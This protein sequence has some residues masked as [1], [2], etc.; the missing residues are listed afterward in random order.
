M[1]RLVTLSLKGGVGKTTLALNLGMAL[2]ILGHRVLLVD[3][4]PQQ[5]LTQN[6][7]VEPYA[8][9]GV[10]FLLTKDMK[11][12]DL[13]IEK[14]YL[15]LLPAGKRLKDTEVAL[16]Q[17]VEKIP[18]VINLL[19][20]GLEEYHSQYDYIIVDSPPNTGLLAVN[21]LIFAREIV[22]PVQCHPMGLR[23]AK[24]TLFFIHKIR[25]YYNSGLKISAVIP[26]MF[27]ARNTLSKNVLN[28][29]ERLFNN[30]TI[31]SRVRVNVDIARASGMQKS[32]FEYRA[33]SRGAQDFLSL[34][35]EIQEISD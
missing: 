35:R 11:L 2:G 19:K 27:D 9:K 30:R 10:E 24:R 20:E 5:D 26:M 1:R 29:L 28:E 6:M 15:H 8:I 12:A 14:K 33:H 31:K 25:N 4:D 32:I 17:T 18:M 34:A 7:G 16:A 22:I 3:M 13:V 23:G 21:S